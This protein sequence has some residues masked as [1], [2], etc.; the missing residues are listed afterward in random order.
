MRFKFLSACMQAHSVPCADAS[1]SPGSTSPRE[2]LSSIGMRS[3]ASS[4][5]RTSSKASS[6]IWACDS[7]STSSESQP[8]EFIP[9][10]DYDEVSIAELVQAVNSGC[11]T[12]VT[13]D[14]AIRLLVGLAK[15]GS[16]RQ[17]EA[18]A[19]GLSAIASGDNNLRGKVVTLGG[20]DVILKLL[21]FGMPS[22]KTAALIALET[23]AATNARHIERTP[24]AVLNIER[25][26]KRGTPRQ[27]ESAAVIFKLL[28]SCAPAR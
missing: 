16:T 13:H 14:R 21:T 26:T 20:L 27:R 4:P 28:H 15:E 17:R 18:A 6:S 8:Y 7:A 9:H 12:E 22:E 11:Q 25:L 5:S 3:T 1:T 23:F 10:M 2:V 19:A 24:Q